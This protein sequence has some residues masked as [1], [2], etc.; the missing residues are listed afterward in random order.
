MRRYSMDNVVEI[1]LEG[2]EV[3]VSDEAM[4]ESVGF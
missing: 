4:G 3:V 2:L 1:D